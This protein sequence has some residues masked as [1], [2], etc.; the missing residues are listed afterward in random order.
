MKGSACL[1]VMAGLALLGSIVWA[2]TVDDMKPADKKVAEKLGVSVEQVKRLQTQRAMS[3]HALDVLPANKLQ[4]AVLRLEY[5]DLPRQRAA[6]LALRQKDEKGLIPFGAR[7]R[8]ISQLTQLRQKAPLARKVSGLPA[9]PGISPKHL[10]P[11]TAGL[12]PD[13]TSWVSLG[14]GNIGG[15][16]RAIVL[17]PTNPQIIWAGGAGGG[18]WKSEDGGNHFFPANDLMVCL[19]TSCLVMDPGNPQII[20]AGTGEGF[21]NT[22]AIR[23]AGIF[24]TTDGGTTWSQ[25]PQTNNN[26][27]HYINRLALS[28]DGKVLLAATRSDDPGES[29]I[30]RSE[31]PDRIT[32]T[33]TIDGE[34]ADL[35]FNPTNDQ[36]K[37]VAGGLRDGGIYF[38]TDGGQQWTPATHAGTWDSRVEVAYA[39]KDPSIVYASVNVNHGELWRSN[40]G[41]KTYAKV[42]TGTNYLGDQGWY[43]NVVWAGD[44]AN[45]D[46]VLVG[47]I[48]LYRSTDG[49][50]TLTDVSTWWASPTSAH[51]DHHAIVAHSKFGIDNNKTV[52]FGNDGGLYMTDDVYQVGSDPQPP[53]TKGWKNL[54]NSYGVTQF[55]GAAGNVASGN[56]VGGAQDNGTLRF[57]PAGGPDKY[58][59]MFG[60]DGGYCAADPSDP[61]YF[62]GEYVFLNI[63]RSTDGGS[64]ADYISGQFWNGSDWVF[65]PFPYQIPDAKSQ[66]ANFIAPFVL[67]PNNANRIL[68]GGMSLW[69][70]NDPKTPNTPTKGPKW[71]AIKTSTGVPISAVAVAPGNSS[72]IWVGHNNGD[73]YVTTEGTGATPAWK[74]VD[75][76]GTTHLPRRFCT[77]ITLDPHDPPKVVYVTFGGYS[78]DNV[79]KTMDGGLTWS[80]LSAGLPE[81]PVY[82]LVVH[83]KNSKYLYLGTGVGVFASEDGGQNWSPTN[84]GPTY[85]SVDELLWLGTSLVAATHGR[86]MFKIDLPLNP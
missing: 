58:T 84:E 2:A 45:A 69:Q 3:N 29:G 14:P 43:D 80:S 63:C 71:A 33:K 36:T 6:F 34:F 86:G 1:A 55:Y 77:R 42:N 54:N 18:I 24:R 73:V 13:H 66:Q 38:S 10:L 5:P 35:K 83:P 74:K 32:W 20:Y 37:A 82:S 23:G 26:K 22:D 4:R 39:R 40:D 51:A 31:D 78:K 72:I 64:T 50:A 41:G 25:L 7:L 30:Y 62:Y 67:D 75:A 65:K 12:N 8:A 19:A 11:P 49:G 56:I 47:G 28:P 21:F 68:A 27:F 60:G 48:D 81:A 53:R 16:T 9:G 52:F 15:R 46:L 57:T 70:T 59:E 44:P 17:D 85:C 76:S 61:N 79:W